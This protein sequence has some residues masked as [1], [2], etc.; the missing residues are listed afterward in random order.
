MISPSTADLLEEAGLARPV[1]DESF[2][3]FARLVQRHLGVPTA[4]VTIVLP[5]SQVYPGAR[6]L[7]EPYQATRRTT[8]AD[9]LCGETISRGRRLVVSDLR[10]DPRLSR[11]ATVTELG[12]AAYAGYPIF[13]RHGTAVGTVCALDQQPRSWS[14]SDLAT[15]AD[16][17]AACTAEL[18][19][20]LERRRA[21][22]IQQVAVNATRRTRLLLDLTER[23]A[24]ATTL[25]EI[26]E[27]VRASA[28]GIGTMWAGMALTDASGTALTLVEREG[29]YP[30]LA[31]HWPL[32]QPAVAAVTRARRPTFFRD[33]AAV[34]RKL[35][36]FAPWVDE[37]MGGMAFLPLVSHDRLLGLLALLWRGPHDHDDESRRTA[38]ALGTGVTQ[39]L[40][41]VRVLDE[42]HRVAA[43]LQAAML[44]DLPSVP[45]LDLATTYATATRTDQVGGDWYDAVVRD[46]RSSVLMIGDVTGHDMQAA[47]RMGQLRSMLRTLV[48]RQDAPPARLLRELDQANRGLG[49]A[50][51]GTALVARLDR[52]D[53]GGC[54][55]RWASAGHPRPVVIRA[56]GRVEEL[57]GRPDLILGV[58]PT[59]ARRDHAAA[60]RPGDTLLLYTDGLVESRTVSYA[61]RLTELR[62][63]LADLAGCP[64]ADLPRLLVDRLVRTEQHDDVAVLAARVR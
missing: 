45:Y 29:T 55:L 32:V 43:T 5:D 17:A 39:A 24:G 52:S 19:L 60:L 59:T 11:T 6:G 41:R 35:P 20:R 46:A 25:E 33:G 30:H 63:A 64:T 31:R 56:D 61:T 48:W 14:A 57:P 4:L 10:A 1:A 3:R 8:L 22:R 27:A 18:R 51:S 23:F 38:V 50:A 42:R 47:A 36:A 13:D 40:A 58:D 53:D 12:M 7:P 9:P 49:L 16:L 54:R 62:E 37:S 44:T 26:I 21:H 15:L 28:S 34:L 2:D